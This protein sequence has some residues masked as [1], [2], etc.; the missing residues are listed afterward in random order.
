MAVPVHRRWDIRWLIPSEAHGHVCPVCQVRLNGD[1]TD[2][3]KPCRVCRDRRHHRRDAWLQGQ[4]G[5]DTIWFEEVA[6]RNGRLALLTLSLDLEDWLNG[7]RVDSLRAQAIPEWARFNPVLDG[8]PNPLN[9]QSAYDSLLTYVRGKLVSFNKND[10][11][12]KNLSEGYRHENDWQIF[13]LQ[14]RRG[15]RG[16][17]SMEQPER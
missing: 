11:V 10:P 4:L 15:P 12:L 13:F 8:T 7:K 5:H 6:D 16:R 1:P 14:D 2:K 9:P 17:T 3:G